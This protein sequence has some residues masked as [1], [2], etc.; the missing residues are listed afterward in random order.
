MRFIPPP[1]HGS[2]GHGAARTCHVDAPSVGTMP[3]RITSLAQFYELSMRAAPRLLVID[4]HAA[5]CGPCVR[6]AAAMDCDRRHG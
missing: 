4:F 3:E 5:W 1:C 6:I 2:G